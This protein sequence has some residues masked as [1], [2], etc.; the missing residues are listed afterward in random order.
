MRLSIKLL[1][2]ENNLYDQQ[3]GRKFHTKEQEMT[4]FLGINYIMSINKLPTIKGYWE[5]KHHIGNEGMRNVMARS[6]F[7]NIL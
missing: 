6:K 4:V 1:V 3:N 7:E 2:D 5:C